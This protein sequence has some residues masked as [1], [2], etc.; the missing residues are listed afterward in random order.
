M[1]L[2]HCLQLVSI[3]VAMLAIQATAVAHMLNAAVTSAAAVAAIHSRHVWDQR[4]LMLH[5]SLDNITTAAAIAAS[6][7]S[8][9]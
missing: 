9:V 8:H 2:Q 6:Y 7:S 5:S 4:I 1:Y 3:S